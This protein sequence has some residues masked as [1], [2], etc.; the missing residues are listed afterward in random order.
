M[1]TIQGISNK[2]T[3]TSFPEQNKSEN[4]L[5]D[6]KTNETIQK[7]IN[8]I[9]E[10]SNSRK[11]KPDDNSEIQKFQKFQKFQKKQKT[12]MPK[13]YLVPPL[14][15]SQSPVNLG[16]KLKTRNKYQFRYIPKE[17]L[18]EINLF[19]L[20]KIKSF[21][22]IGYS[23][24]SDGILGVMILLEYNEENFANVITSY[25][26]HQQYSNRDKSEKDSNLIFAETL[27]NI[28]TKDRYNILEPNNFSNEVEIPEK[29]VAQMLKMEYENYA[30]TLPDKRQIEPI[31]FSRVLN[32]VSGLQVYASCYVKG[33]PIYN[34][35]FKVPNEWRKRQ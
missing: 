16:K 5:V 15:V 6:K 10:Y 18:K 26:S 12:E 11:R 25:K 13:T 1:S 31:V 3:I 28:P 19:N 2:I 17:F 32:G 33:Q 4:P 21:K 22:K 30:K 8:R 7:V 29:E 35:V 34:F 14:P 20:T 27:I 24:T 23:T 9:N